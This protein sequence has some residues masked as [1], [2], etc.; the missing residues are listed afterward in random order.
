MINNVGLT[1]YYSTL[2][3][4]LTIE[5][6]KD[7]LKATQFFLVDKSNINFPIQGKYEVTFAKEENGL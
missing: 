6:L 2:T 7:L 4:T 5:V 3:S 1:R